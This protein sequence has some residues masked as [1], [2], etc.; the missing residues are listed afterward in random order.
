MRFRFLVPEAQKSKLILYTLRIFERSWNCDV[1]QQRFFWILDRKRRNCCANLVA[2]RMIRLPVSRQ[3]RSLL[4]ERSDRKQS[5]ATFQL[6]DGTDIIQLR[7]SPFA[8]SPSKY[9]RFTGCGMS[10][11]HTYLRFQKAART[12][13]QST[14]RLTRSSERRFR[15]RRP[16]SERVAERPRRVF[17]PKRRYSRAESVASKVG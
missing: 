15:K 1:I 16:P 8:T 11:L 7:I 9:R 3:V 4:L 12:P 6:T 2:F 14:A 5:R 17:S 10:Y 13:S